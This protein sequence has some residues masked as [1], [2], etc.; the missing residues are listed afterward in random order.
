MSYQDSCAPGWL[1]WWNSFNLSFNLYYYDQHNLA[2]VTCQQEIL[3]PRVH[4]KSLPRWVVYYY[5]MRTLCMFYRLCNGC[6]MLFI[7]VR[8]MAEWCRSQYNL[9]EMGDIEYHVNTCL[10]VTNLIIYYIVKSNAVY[11]IS[12]LHYYYSVN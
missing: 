10:H 3:T 1:L 7:L 9:S 2:G 12:L 11:Y 6:P 4:L 5:S 8:G